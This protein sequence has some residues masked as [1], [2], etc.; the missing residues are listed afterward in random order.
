[1][2]R[3]VATSEIKATRAARTDSMS[4]LPNRRGFM[5]YVESDEAVKAAQ[6]GEAAVIYIDLPNNTPFH[7]LNMFVILSFFLTR[8]SFI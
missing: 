3:Q 4:K 5:E 7:S 8:H 2:A 6:R 1:M